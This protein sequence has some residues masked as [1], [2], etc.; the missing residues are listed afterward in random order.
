MGHYRL[1]ADGQSGT[2]ELQ[3]AVARATNEERWFAV[4]DSDRKERHVRASAK[5]QKIIDECGNRHVPY[6]C[7]EGQEMEN[8]LPVG[9]FFAEAGQHTRKR[10]S[11]GLGS[12][13]LLFGKLARWVESDRE[14]WNR[15]FGRAV[16]DK[17]LTDLRQIADKQVDRSTLWEQAEGLRQLSEADRMVDDLKTR[18]GE[19]IAKALVARMRESLDANPPAPPAATDFSQ[20]QQ[21]DLRKLAQRLDEWL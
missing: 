21:A 17:A 6:H 14:R 3:K 11:A 7:L 5:I 9:W 12:R 20:L 15:D 1:V 19:P 10:R 16:V 8:Y 13:P 4:F 18:F 2:G